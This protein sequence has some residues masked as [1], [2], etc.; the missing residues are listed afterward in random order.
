M[1]TRGQVFPLI[2]MAILVLVGVVGFA[3]DAGY[4]QYR[5]RVQQTAADSA[6]MT[7]AAEFSL[8]DWS[9]AAK[10]DAATNGF[11]DTTSGT[12]PS[13]PTVGT[14]CVHVASPPDSPDPY[15]STSGAVEV[16]ITSYNP[17]FFESVFQIYN[18]PITTKAV[19]TQKTETANNCVL[20]LNGPA[21]FNQGGATPAPGAS[22][23]VYAPNCGMAFNQTTNFHNAV[24]DA[25]G[26]DC[27][28]GCSNGTYT[29]AQPTNSGPVSDPCEW[30][31]YCAAL[32]ASQ[33]PCASSAPA[34][35]TAG[36]VT[37]V[38]PGCYPSGLDLSKATNVVFTCGFYDIQGTLNASANGK[39]ATP[40]NISQS[41]PLNGTSGVTFYV[42]GAGSI[43]MKND[44]INL[45]APTAGNYS[46]WSAAEQNVLI[47]QSPSDTNT[48]NMQS[49]VANCGLANCN[50]YFS[51]M[52]YAPNATL[53]YNQFSST[54]STQT[55]DVL[56]IVGT[57]NANGGSTGVINAP[58]NTGS[59]TITVPVLGE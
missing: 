16:Q 19:A 15:S 7:G 40:I 1:G 6:A 52:I 17:T 10:Q 8:G 5:E 29:N 30:I 56:I 24:V 59:Y 28:Q 47:Y 43:V 38:Y 37:T 32:A 41:C 57:L 39:N 58:G 54:S 14:V 51:G 12:C 44:V 46:E 42:T 55:G 48:V 45:S 33:P 4:H 23:A 34:P 31:S 35:T 2:A 21:N 22:P 50:S 13:S 9:V 49:A 26:L 18:V 53:N 11:R 27:V 3:V 36:N 20:V 25:A